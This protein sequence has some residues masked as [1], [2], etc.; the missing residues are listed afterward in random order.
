MMDWIPVI[1]NP[2]SGPKAAVLSDLNQVFRTAG[3]RW[4]VEIT[5]GGGDATRLAAQLAA[6]GAPIVAAYGGDGTISEVAG[7]LSGTQTALGLLPGGTAN[8]LAFEFGIPRNLTLAARLLVSEHAI[9]VVDMG[10]VDGRKFLLRAGAG[11]E[12][13]T[14][15]YTPRGLKDQLGLLAYGLAG[16]QALLEARRVAYSLEVDGQTAEA[17]GIL[18]TVANA[19]HLGVLPALTLTPPIDI[20]DGLLDVI[21]FDRIDLQNMVALL[22]KRLDS[23]DSPGNLQH[24]RVKQATIQAEPAQA[25]QVDGDALGKTPMTVRSIP[26]ALRVIVPVGAQ[27]SV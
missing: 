5:Q 13:A 2:A 25:T 8:V 12:A 3:I 9:R 6:Q 1:I 20:T 19:G 22:S 18:C 4:S 17:H 7:G 16:L 24:W 15:E 14:I 21:V 27:R 23:L 26:Q 10:E 11:L